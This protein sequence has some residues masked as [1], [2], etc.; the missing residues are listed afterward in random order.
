M[1]NEIEFIGH[2]GLF[3]IGYSANTLVTK[4]RFVLLTYCR[5]IKDI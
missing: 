3:K 5:E 1:V 2:L 4:H